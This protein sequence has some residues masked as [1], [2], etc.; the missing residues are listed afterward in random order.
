[1]R[2]NLI[3]LLLIIFQCSCALAVL[4]GAAAGVIIYD[5]RSLNTMHDDIKITRQI[6]KAIDA[7]PAFTGS[8]IVVASFN[9]ILLLT[10]ET[11]RSELKNKIEQI[12]RQNSHIYRIYDEIQIAK[13]INFN[14]QAQDTWI[15][16][17]VRTTLLATKNLESGSLRIITEN[18][19]VYLM[20]TV[21]KDQADLA[22][23]EVRL[24]PKV[25][26]VVRVFQYIQ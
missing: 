14:Q 26:Q 11:P 19:I 8:R 24:I 23:E 15:T 21:T 1:M 10:G 20:G 18:Q 25:K 4:A 22:V 16:S 6:K 7:D 2:K 17:Q 12:A 5:R 3:I 13:P 9:R